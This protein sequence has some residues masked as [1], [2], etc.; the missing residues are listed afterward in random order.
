MI[1]HT[2]K[3]KGD[4]LRSYKVLMR[5]LSKEGFYQE[6]KRKEYFKSKS[7]VNR[8]R[9]ARSVAKEQKRQKL[10]ELQLQRA[11]Y[12]HKRKKVKQR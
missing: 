3:Y 11:E 2:R 8:E 6:S 4:A 10:K 7:E 1:V 12:G 9:L 5:K